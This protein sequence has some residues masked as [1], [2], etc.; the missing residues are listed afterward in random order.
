MTTNELIIV[1]ILSIFCFSCQDNNQHI[2]SNS[3]KVQA[4]INIKQ[5][6]ISC[7]KVEKRI[8]QNLVSDMRNDGFKLQKVRNWNRKYKN[9]V[10]LNNPNLNNDTFLV[11]PQKTEWKGIKHTK[12][13]HNSE[14]TNISFKNSE[15][16]EVAV[17]KNAEISSLNDIKIVQ[18]LFESDVEAQKST[19][20][21][22]L[23]SYYTIN[24]DGLKNPN[25][26][27]IHNCAIYFCR[28]FSA[29]TSFKPVIEAFE[30]K[31][32]KVNIMRW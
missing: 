4:E 8:F 25:C 30:R 5:K 27:W 24:T 31:N 2:K 15:I 29:S 12:E 32:E 23:I 28:T 9:H 13:F 6:E 18:F 16:T 17:G 19:E 21:L 1:L 10:N 26:W 22:K 11:L 3:S 14:I 7:Y 20:K